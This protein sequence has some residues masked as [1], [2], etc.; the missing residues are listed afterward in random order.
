MIIGNGVDYP[1]REGCSKY[2]FFTVEQI[3]VF[4]CC[5][6]HKAYMYVCQCLS[7]HMSVNTCY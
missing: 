6:V 1:V 4:V 3:H 7:I 5:V 2:D